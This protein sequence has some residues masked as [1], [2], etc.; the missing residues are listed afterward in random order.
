MW[1][2]PQSHSTNHNA[3]KIRYDRGRAGCTHIIFPD[4]VHPAPSWAIIGLRH[5]NGILPLLKSK[6]LRL[7]IY[8]ITNKWFLQPLG[9]AN[10][11]KGFFIVCTYHLINLKYLNIKEQKKNFTS[12]LEL[13][14]THFLRL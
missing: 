5:H 12:Y 3:K 7:S 14:E 1:H 9:P 11:Q 8:N 6:T 10:T 2:V 4:P 13:N